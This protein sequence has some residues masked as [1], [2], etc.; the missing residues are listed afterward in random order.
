VEIV[1]GHLI[2]VFYAAALLNFLISNVT[3]MSKDQS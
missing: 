3:R 2:N 1:I